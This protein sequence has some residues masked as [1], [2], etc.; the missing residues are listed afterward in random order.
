MKQIGIDEAVGMNL[1]FVYRHL[2]ELVLVLSDSKEDKYVAL[3]AGTLDQFA[4]QDIGLTIENDDTFDPS[5]MPEAEAIRLGFYANEDEC[6][7]V[8][9]ARE[10]LSEKQQRAHDELEYIRLKRIFEKPKPKRRK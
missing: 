4:S 1:K 2:D 3:A 6:D 5:W 8:V 7:A 10:A 9:A